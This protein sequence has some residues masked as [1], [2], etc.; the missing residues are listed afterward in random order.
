MLKKLIILL[1]VAAPLGAFAQEKI[2]YVNSQELFSLMP[3]I[4][5][6]ESQLAT[7]QADIRKNLEA[8]DAEYNK[9]I[10]E[11]QD[12]K[13]EATESVL[14]DRQKQIQQ[15]QERFQT[16]SENSRKEL[17]DLQSKLIT[18][19]QEKL[20]KAIQDVGAEQGY[21]YIVESGVLLYTGTNAIN[22]DKFVKAKVGIK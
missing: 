9:K 17:E 7:K 1:F 16:Y 20:R 10:Q 15:I 22:A 4:G 14:L 18:P 21:T 19:I 8:M 6:V 5:G 11:F 12:S 3:E 13:E 2:A